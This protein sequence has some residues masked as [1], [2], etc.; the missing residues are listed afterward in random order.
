MNI[1]VL[2]ED[3]VAAARMQCDKHVVKMTTETAQLLSTA[4]RVL[5]GSVT[6]YTKNG[7]HR[8]HWKM[9]D[10]EKESRLYRATHV[11]HPCTIWTASNSANYQWLYRHFIAL[12]NEYTR[13]Y[14]KIHRCE[15][16]LA[17]ML[18]DVP[19]NIKVSRMMTPF[20]KAMKSAP[21]EVQNNP[22]PIE[23]YRQFYKTKPF[24]MTWKNAEKPIWYDVSI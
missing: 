11:K 3:P 6:V 20:V 18:R 7:R 22:D 8:I 9:H 12:C 16:L 17:D 10:I 13:R 15:T 23:A 4:H 5:D 1:F 21:P 14:E 19:Q 2:S 24:R